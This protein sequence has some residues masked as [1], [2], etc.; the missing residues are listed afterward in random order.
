MARGGRGHGPGHRRR[1]ARADLPAVL[2]ADGG[3]TGL[4]LAIAK[5]LASALG[6][7]IDLDSRG[8][9]RIR[10]ELVL[11]AG[12][13]RGLLGARAR[14][15]R[16]PRRSG[17]SATALPARLVSTA[18]DAVEPLVHARHCDQVDE[19]RQVVDP[20][21]PLGEQVALEPLEPPITWF[22]E[23]RT[24]ASWRATGRLRAHAVAERVAD[25]RRED[26]LE[27]VA[28]CASASIWCAALERRSSAA[29]TYRG[30]EASNA[31]RPWRP[32]VTSAV[33]WMPPSSTTTS[34]RS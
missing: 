26:D 22:E 23:P 7:R 11:P 9:A 6:G 18:L 24:S 21:V 34:R 14:V 12:D 16:R 10:F 29:A 19:Q 8:R 3:G 20:R 5:E 17:R 13:V 32:T 27:L 4:G 33:G 28:V 25:R 31:D 1:G 15:A 2:V 30:A